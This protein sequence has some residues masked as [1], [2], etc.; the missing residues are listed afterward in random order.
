MT[1]KIMTHT[2]TVGF[3][4]TNAYICYDDNTRKGVLIDPGGDGPKI[5]KIIADKGISIAAILLTHGHLDHIA[6]A[7]ELRHTLKVPTL[8]SKKDAELANNQ[9]YNGTA[10]FRMPPI[11]AAVDEYLQDGQELDLLADKNQSADSSVKI[12]AMHT[13]GHTHGH[14]CYYLPDFDILY[15]GDHLFR[16]S[17]GRYDLPTGD[18]TALRQSMIQILALPPHTTVYPGH[19]PSTT[20]EHEQTNNLLWINLKK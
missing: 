14:I 3:A 12:I 4:Q 5:R 18:F 7:D 11:N 9:D 8:A 17:Y 19:G 13:P 6:A 15:S 20:I 10:V 2:I 16:E 1:P